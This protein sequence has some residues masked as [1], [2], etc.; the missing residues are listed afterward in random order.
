M[1][2]VL[3]VDDDADI[4]EMMELI[5]RGEGH[6]V[7][8]AADGG[9]AL[10]LLAKGLLPNVVVL[11]LMMPGMNGWDFRSRMLSDPRMAAI[12][13]VVVTGDQTASRRSP[14]LKATILS[15]P[16]SVDDLLGA[17]AGTEPAQ[18]TA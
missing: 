1:S 5:L 2:L 13:T 12:P 16:F 6:Q 18:P 4:R 14:E 3:I 17:I 8:T 7:V 11:D 10:S 9:E 15:K